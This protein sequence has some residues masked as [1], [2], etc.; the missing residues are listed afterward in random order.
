MMRMKNVDMVHGKLIKSIILYA[1][2]I[3]LMGLIQKL[4]NAVDVMVLGAMAD[5]NAVASVGATSSL[6]HLLIDSFFGISNGTRVVLSRMLGAR[7][8]E[9]AR[10]TASTSMLIAVILGVAT[11]VLGFVFA[12]IFLDWTNCPAE[13]LD[14][15][16][17][18]LRLYL[19]A[20]PAILIYN[21]GSAILEVS[22]DTRRPLL[23]MM[24]SGA[25]NVVLNF[26]LCMVLEE[27]VAAVAIATAVSQ[28]VGAVLVVLRLF[29][30][31]EICQ[32]RWNRM[33]WSNSAFGSIMKNGLPIA[34]YSALYPMANLQIQAQVN[35]FGPAYMAGAT[36]TSNLDGILSTVA[37]APMASAITAFV[38][39]NMGAGK[40][41]RVKKTILFCSSVSIVMG[42]ILGVIGTLCSRPLVSLFVSE[43]A[44]IAAGRERLWYVMFPHFIACANTCLSRVIQS[45]GY[46]TFTTVNSVV[47]VLVFRVFWTAVVYN[48]NP[49]FGML[50]LCFPVSW[51]LACAINLPVTLYLYFG[52]YKKGTLK[53]ML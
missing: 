20:A 16:V 9:K 44:A 11:A 4:F 28:L 49:T 6:V 48:A 14:G 7:E 17:T 50:C 32:L 13:C 53:K 8:E 37:A 15:A 12:P 19:L 51:A 42:L 46:S 40:P 47:T 45:F 41:E 29:R 3:L 2:P 39:Q 52:R 1:I 30:M 22:G 24:I 18:Y 26:A 27:K 43:E 33:R 36:A 21:F 34:L 25:L 35:S 31:D 23:Y 38:G 5:T 10:K